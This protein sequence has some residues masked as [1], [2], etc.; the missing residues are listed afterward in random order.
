M[1]WGWAGML[2]YWEFKIRAAG[3]FDP[4]ERHVP[5]ERMADYINMQKEGHIMCLWIKGQETIGIAGRSRVG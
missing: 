5:I 2:R 4:A 1:C 3:P